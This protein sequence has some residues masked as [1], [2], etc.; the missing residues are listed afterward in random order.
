MVKGTRY[1][2]GPSH[3]E[4]KT[5]RVW[6]H[7]ESS[8]AQ[9]VLNTLGG[10]P[11]NEGFLHN[12]TIVW[13]N[14]IWDMWEEGDALLCMNTPPYLHP[15]ANPHSHRRIT[16]RNQKQTEHTKPQQNR[17]TSLTIE[18]KHNLRHRTMMGRGRNHTMQNLHALFAKK[19]Y[20]T[21]KLEPTVGTVVCIVHCPVFRTCKEMQMWGLLSHA[22]QVGSWAMWQA[23]G[24]GPHIGCD[25]WRQ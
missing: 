20:V 8:P 1:F 4:K 16:L 14:Q 5:C 19:V 22:K 24:G 23:G 13:R 15:H 25:G 18:K 6:R 12:T 9:G 2:D 21:Q 17:A 11:M 3:I 10:P 7:C